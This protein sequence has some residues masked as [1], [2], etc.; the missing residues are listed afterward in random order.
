M[1]T[2]IMKNL[3]GFL[4]RSLLGLFFLLL[5]TVCNSSFAQ[6]YTGR[7]NTYAITNFTE[8]YSNISGTT[9]GAADDAVYSASLPFN[10]NYDN[11]PIPQFTT[12]WMS[13]NGFVKLGGTSPGSGCCSNNFGS[14][15]TT[16][17]QTLMVLSSDNVVQSPG[18]VSYTTTGTS[19]NRVFVIEWRNVRAFGQA[20]PF[21]DFQ[22]RLYETTNNIDFFYKDLGM[23]M[24]GGT[25][26][27]G[28]HSHLSQSFMT[29][30]AATATNGT[31]SSNF[32]FKTPAPN[33]QLSLT[34]KFIS[35]GSL[36][37]G[38]STFADVTV[39][40]VGTEQTLILQNAGASGANA[41]D[42][43]IE[44][45]PTPT[46]TLSVGQSATYRIRF[47][48]T[49]G[50]NRLGT[51]TV[52]TNGRD[53]GVQSTTLSGFG[54]APLIQTSPSLI[55][56]SLRVPIGDT[57]EASVVISSIGAASL[58]FTGFPIT[59]DGEG[60]ENDYFIS[61]YPANPMAPGT[62]DTLK[63]KFAPTVEGGRTAVL[64]INSNALNLPSIDVK[65][66]GIG[67]IPRMVIAP[68]YL[69]FDSTRVSDTTCKMITVYNVGSDTLRLKNQY[70]ASNDG[71]FSFTALTGNGI[72]IPANDSAF[73]PVCFTP[74]QKGTRQ[75]RIRVIGN[76]PLTSE[77]YPRD[78]SAV[79]VE[80]RGN[81]MPLDK[82]I[83]AMKDI[84]DVI[85]GEEGNTSLVLTNLGTDP[86]VVKAPVISG[87][88]AS[89]FSVTKVNFPASVA[90]GASISMSVSAK[91]LAR[92][93]RNA[94]IT[95]N[96]TSEGRPY[97]VAA[98]VKANALLASASSNTTT[99]AFEKLL[100]GEVTTKTVEVTNNGDIHQTFA[101]TLTGSNSFTFDNPTI[102]VPAGEKGIYS[103]TFA[104]KT[105]GTLTGTLT[106]KG[107]HI[108]DMNINLN[109][110]GEKEPDITQ[111][112]SKVSEMDGFTLEQNSPNPAAGYTTFTFTA[113]KQA[114]LRLYL[115]DIS[116]KVVKEIA[117]SSYT[118]GKHSVSI[119]TKEL[120]SGSYVYILESGTTK[121]MRQMIVTK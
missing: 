70:F 30:S 65:M 113:P 112:V 11:I 34:P 87:T 9:L 43:V 28:L 37:T 103:I 47:T 93:E 100:L 83:I 119:D 61:H 95:F 18:V 89:E 72:K 23:V 52:V 40:H 4:K 42:F 91:P 108:A 69:D 84:D 109:G 13:T 82:S 107:S 5:L 29:V 60:S 33:V 27:V 121:I 20:G 102:E 41:T 115:A 56:K 21:T 35:F 55:F 39:T 17:R 117:N 114:S 86:I 48:P 67:V 49:A 62:T 71:D 68:T 74:L 53:S 36:E 63:I 1:R 10:F 85:I 75:A 7:I 96:L 32:R 22:V 79:D 6:F 66:K 94:D 51:F 111:S 58:Y 90:A 50:G 101:A 19:P 14:S 31:P 80:I 97:S 105:E 81:A 99:L 25:K 38:Q 12:I 120:A 64:T 78:T 88:N 46:N 45:G 110:T 16:Y 73:I 92:G 26:G 54:V 106:I 15:S 3:H 77:Y 118:A 8:T 44:S 24:G 57:A 2:F 59:G 104:P 116:G 76:I 98:G